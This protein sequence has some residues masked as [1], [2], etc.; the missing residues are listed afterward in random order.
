M[1]DQMAALGLEFEFVDALRGKDYY[2]DPALY[3]MK[4]ALRVEL[5]N[6]T[7]GEVGCALSHQKVYDL[8]EERAL[9]YAFVMEDDAV[10]SPDVPEVLRRLEGRIRPN[11]L[12]TLERCDVYSNKY[13]EPLYKEYRLAKPAMV[14][15]GSMSQAAGYAITGEAA[16]K[17][18]SINRPV[19]VPADSW[20]QYVGAIRFLG[21]VPTLT[22]IRQNTSFECTTQDYQRKEFTRRT[23]FSMLFYAFK[24]RSWPGRLL[25]RAAKR[26]L[27]RP[28]P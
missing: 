1:A 6:M 3:D 20:G 27:K 13:A 4:K 19:F 23:P 25:V 24:T 10:I 9:P 14:K 8:I 16:R 28:K 18:R 15:Y 22:L 17:I 21:V 5:R 2:G 7:P 11:D 26:L 12:V